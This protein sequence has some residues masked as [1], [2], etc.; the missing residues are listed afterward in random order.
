MTALRIFEADGEPG[1]GEPTCSQ[2]LDAYLAD[3]A[4]ELAANT[5]ADRARI[6]RAFCE[7]FGT[8][9]P[10]DV[11]PSEVKAWILGRPQWKAANT[12]WG[13]LLALKRL[14]NWAVDDR[15]IA[16]SPIKKLA[17][18]QGEPRRAIT[19]AE[20]ALMLRS[21]DL[22]FR[23]LLTFLRQT[24][25]RPGEARKVEWEWVDWNRRLIAIPKDQHKTG[26]KTGKARL[27]PLNRSA[28]R[29]L[30]YLQRR[31][32]IASGAIFRNSFGKPW[33]RVALGQR[34]TEI[35]ASAGLPKDAT[36]HGI[37][38]LWCTTGA[39]NSGNLK[40]VSEAAGHARLSTFEK[41]YCHLD[42]DPASLVEAAE[43]AGRRQTDRRDVPPA[44]T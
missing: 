23:Q 31:R 36:L 9:R 2:I 30:L 1:T 13:A 10:A 32:L 16:F 43:A 29:L 15:F 7:T 42:K 38:H 17:L 4:T 3:Q 44:G 22:P 12:R 5:L 34:L 14:F 21:S 20:F 11:H 24:G 25:A 41:Y 40:L 26:K 8:R 19:E 18:S 35:R 33:T 39:R 27:I 6:C 37:R 28:V